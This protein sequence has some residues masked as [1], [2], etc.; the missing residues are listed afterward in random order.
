MTDQRKGQIAYAILKYRMGKEGIPLNREE[1][2][3]SIGNLV[4]G[5][6]PNKNLT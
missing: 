4:M 2:K 5:S 6:V 1:L 3:R